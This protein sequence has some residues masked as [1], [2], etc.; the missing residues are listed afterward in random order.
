MTTLTDQ[1]LDERRRQQASEAAAPPAMPAPAPAPAPEPEP[2]QAPEAPVQSVGAAPA[3][4]PAPTPNEVAPEPITAES[5]AEHRLDPNEVA[6][7]IINA[8][9]STTPAE[10]AEGDVSNEED[11][12]VSALLDYINTLREQRN[13]RLTPYEQEQLERRQRNDR[14][15]AGV[16]DMARA[17]ANL[18]ATVNYAPNAYDHRTAMAPA[19]QARFD[20]M[21]A[22]RQAESDR[23]YDFAAKI[24][25][26]EQA[27]ADKRAAARAARAKAE[28]DAAQAAAE[29]R[30]KYEI[31]MLKQQ[32]LNA[33]AAADRDALD[34][35]AAA[36]RDSRMSIAR[37]NHSTPAARI[38]Q[39]SNHQD[40]DHIIP[41]TVGN[42]TL[43]FMDKDK[44]NYYAEINGVARSI[45][46]QTSE[47]VRPHHHNLTDSTT[48][49]T[50]RSIRYSRV[51]DLRQSFPS[52]GP[53]G[54]S[55]WTGGT[56]SIYNT[57]PGANAH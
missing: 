19:V 41:V 32:G 15:V 16:G 44:A 51:P 42:Q 57:Y 21:M 7:R 5:L 49:D 53:G 9:G 40:A 25:Q 45:P 13:R 17:L 47:S 34:A 54:L 30:A 6:D 3:P 27:I 52:V 33:R 28:A 12:D 38:P 22:E 4:A 26:A 37:Y 48:I 2:E 36:D 46:A 20:K 1:E 23:Y 35:R 55:N 29:L 11:V 31:E 14:M 50:T 8:P 56:D 43:W 24:A 10:Q 18:A 39:T